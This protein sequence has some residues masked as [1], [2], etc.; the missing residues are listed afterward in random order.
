[1]LDKMG[2]RR[3]LRKKTI[4]KKENRTPSA[5]GLS[6]NL[7]KV[8]LIR[9]RRETSGEQTTKVIGLPTFAAK[10]PLSLSFHPEL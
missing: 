9:R 1:M 2:N 6:Y 4:K 3:V 8:Y 7:T 10:T 5:T